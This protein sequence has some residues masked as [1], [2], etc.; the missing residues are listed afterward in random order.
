MEQDNRTAT[1]LC[2]SKACRLTLIPARDRAAQA[3]SP[4]EP[5]R[6]A[7]CGAPEDVAAGGFRGRKV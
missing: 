7:F 3:Y 4:Y 5:A 1:S 6:G 2:H